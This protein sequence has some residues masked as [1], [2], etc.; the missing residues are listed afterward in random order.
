MSVPGTAIRPLL[1]ALRRHAFALTGDRRTGDWYVR[2]VLETLLQEPSRIAAGG[3]V[4]LQLFKLLGEVLAID[5]PAALDLADTARP[6]DALHR[7]LMA[8]PILSRHLLLLVSV[9]GLSIREAADLFGIS[10]RGAE[11]HLVWARHLCRE[12]QAPPA[13]RRAVPRH[14]PVSAPGVQ[15]STH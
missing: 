15:A 5:G 13:A 11:A 10:E 4:R 14:A 1:P 9:E 6:G 2:I 3:D 7:R 8:L 12:L